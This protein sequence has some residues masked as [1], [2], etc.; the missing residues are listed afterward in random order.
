MEAKRLR[1]PLSE[2]DARSLRT[3][4]LVLLDGLVVT[5]RDRIHKHLFALR[6]GKGEIPFDLE[7]AVLYHAGPIIKRTADGLTTISCGPTTSQRVQMYEPWVIEHYGIRAV[8][9]KGGMDGRTLEAL[10][11]F[12][13]VYLNTISGAGA[14]LAERVKGIKGGWLVEDFGEPE[15]MWLLEVEDFPAMVTMDS[16]GRSLHEDIRAA[17]EEA[18]KKLLG[19]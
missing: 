1:P 8:M 18:L 9:G 19:V 10:M 7:G 17:S 6:P 16:H 11:R 4:D 12:G 13:A 3:G 15:A 14:F 5:G 2:K